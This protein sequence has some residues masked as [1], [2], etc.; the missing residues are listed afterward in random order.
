MQIN[1]SYN[2]RLYPTEAS[3]CLMNKTFGCSRLVYNTLLYKYKEEKVSILK[4]EKELKINFPFLKEVDSIPL[5][6]SRMN[7]QNAFKAFFDAKKKKKSKRKVGFPKFKK[8]KGSKLSYRTVSTNNNIKIDFASQTLTIPKIGMVRYRD[9]RIFNESIR[10]VTVSK[11][12]T[13]NYYAS[14]LIEKEI[15]PITSTNIL[16]TEIIG[17]DMGV[18]HII[19]TDTGIS[20]KAPRYYRKSEKKLQK[21]QKKF[22]KKQKGSK[23]QEKQRIKVARVHE[24]IRNQRKDFLHKLSTQIVNEYKV[25]G[26]EN[27]A[28]QNMQQN[29]TLA[30]SVSDVAW[31]EF[32][33]M[34]KY[35]SEWKGKYLIKVDR[36][37]PSS[38]LCNHCGFKNETL[39]LSDRVWTCPLCGTCH[40][41]DHNAAKNIKKEI[42]KI[43]GTRIGG[44]FIRPEQEYVFLHIPTVAV[45]NE[46]RNHVL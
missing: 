14:I 20:I 4:S 24:K 23:V 37:F 21:V 2:F 10:S 31:S 40:D 38:K 25:I 22:S 13:G 6:Q 26:I 39:Q 7:L 5:Q 33:G 28:I 41:R 29:K 42:I 12:K 45:V 9:P 8:K 35:K 34:L 46:T 16:D 36:F 15:F 18:T 32:V 3:K 30:K 43:L 1:K 19:T 44:D 27:L 17:L 11:T